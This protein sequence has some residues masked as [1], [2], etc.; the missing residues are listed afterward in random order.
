MRHRDAETQRRHDKHNR[1]ARFRAPTRALLLI[2]C[3][4]LL[5]PCLPGCSKK[6][7]VPAGTPIQYENYARGVKVVVGN[8]LADV[9]VAA[10]S[11]EPDGAERGVAM[12]LDTGKYLHVAPRTFQI[13]G[14]ELYLLD[15][16]GVR[17]WTIDGVETKL[18]ALA[19]NASGQED[20][21]DGR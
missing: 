10:L 1:S 18:E 9:I 11:R 14:N 20:P 12:G 7:D 16:W 17:T 8:P 15:D 3:V 6:I 13:K 2:A 5:A 4:L 21:V 19:A